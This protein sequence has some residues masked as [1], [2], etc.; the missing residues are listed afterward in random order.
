MPKLCKPNQI[1]YLTSQVDTISHVATTQPSTPVTT[2]PTTTSTTSTKATTTVTTPSATVT[3]MP[4][5][6]TTPIPTT[7]EPGKCEPGV[8]TFHV[9]FIVSIMLHRK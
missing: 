4:T 2:Q 9:D 1:Q 8:I 5:T 7:G 6:A 3:T